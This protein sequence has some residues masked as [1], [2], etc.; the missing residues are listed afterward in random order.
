MLRGKR[1]RSFGA[2][3]FVSTGRWWVRAGRAV[4]SRSTATEP[5]QKGPASREWEL[6]RNR[7][8]VVR[9]R[10]AGCE[11]A[12]APGSISSIGPREYMH[13]VH[14]RRAH[15]TSDDAVRL[16]AALNSELTAM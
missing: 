8:A 6:S 2:A 14:I 12:S 15:L 11:G 7:C 13:P 1:G 5:A 16:I 3:L 9:M 10:P 4:R